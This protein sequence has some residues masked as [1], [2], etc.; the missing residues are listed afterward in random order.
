MFNENPTISLI[1]LPRPV[2]V[3]SMV[4]ENLD[5]SDN[6]D[7]FIS[8]ANFNNGTPLNAE[9]LD[10]LTDSGAAQLHLFNAACRTFSQDLS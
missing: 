2:M 6:S 10:V 7:A 9:Q 8:Q 4:M 1:S 5:W 3:A